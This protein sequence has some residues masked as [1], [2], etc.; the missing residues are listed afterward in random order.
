[1][2]QRLI[3]LALLAML[4]SVVSGQQTS[5]IVGLVQDPMGAGVVG[6]A[7]TLTETQTNARRTATTNSIGE[8]NASSLPPGTYRLEVEKAGFQKLTRE[9]VVLTTASTLNVDLKL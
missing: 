5:N 8:Y 6:A 3:A 1:M 7:V 2:I 4:C 9:G